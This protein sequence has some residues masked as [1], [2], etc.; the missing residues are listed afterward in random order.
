MAS[1]VNRIA[2]NISIK[3]N[4]IILKYVEED[5]VVSMN[6]Q[7]F[8]FDS[9]DDD[10]NPAFV[11]ISPINVTQKKVINI[12]D[13]TICLD[14]RN[15]SGKIEYCQ[16]PLLYRCTLQ[17]R[18]LRKYNV[19]TAHQ[20]SITRLDIHANLLNLNISNQQFPMVMRLLYLF[21]N[22]KQGNIRMKAEVGGPSETSQEHEDHEMGES[23]LSWAWNMLPTIF[24]SDDD[25]PERGNMNGHLLHTGIYIDKLE[26]IFKSQEVF[27]DPIVYASRKIKF[28]PFLKLSM[29][30]IFVE[31]IGLG[32]KWFNLQGGVSSMGIYPVGD[33]S[34]GAKHDTD[35]IL[36]MEEI[37]NDLYYR[38]T[39]IDKESDENIGEF[40]FYHC[41]NDIDNDN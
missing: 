40:I 17:L 24:P 26:L 18:M 33:C 8:S 36:K 30:G 7:L 4:N 15:S 2:K 27:G 25:S 20:T 39:L 23:Y 5:I 32:I 35:Y 31:T 41:V 37:H 19:S 34:C 10:W 14:K 29:D 28:I 6:I 3:C 12:Q 11:D 1:L 13:L 21:Y 9:A 38:N 16:E 22:I